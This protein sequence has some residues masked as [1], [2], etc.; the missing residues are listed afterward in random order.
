MEEVTGKE[1]LALTLI[2]YNDFIAE[3][4]IWLCIKSKTPT[5]VIRSVSFVWVNEA[6]S[7]I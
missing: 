1:K 4:T 7:V 6:V 2:V 3:N 5:V